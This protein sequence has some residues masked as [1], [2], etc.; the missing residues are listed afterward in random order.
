LRVSSAFSAWCSI[1]VS[2]NRFKKAG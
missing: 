2:R 1:G